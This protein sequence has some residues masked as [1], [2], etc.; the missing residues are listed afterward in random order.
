MSFAQGLIAG[1]RIAAGWLDAYESSD[2]KRR[3]KL[4]QEE[5]AK[6]GRTENM[7]EM[8]P[9]Y[10]A[11]P[12]EGLAPQPSM[13]RQPAPAPM[14]TGVS[15]ADGDYTSVPGMRTGLQASM[16]PPAQ[17]PVGAGFARGF[18][19]QQIDTARSAGMTM[20]VS[21]RTQ[22]EADIYAKYGLT[23]DAVRSRERAYDLGRQ[24]KSDA[25]AERL[26][27]RAEE[28]YGLRIGETKRTLREGEA[29]RNA[30]SALGVKLAAGETIDLPAIYQVATDMGA[31]PTVLTAFVGD[32]L[33]INKKI[34]DEKVAKMERE[35]REA[36]SS[37]DKLNAY[38]AKNVADPNPDDNIL[39][40]LRP[41]KGGWGIFYGKDL[42]KGTQIYADTKEIPGFQ[43]LAQDMIEKAK[44]NPLGWTIQ[45]LTIEKEAAA[46]AASKASSAASAST[47]GLNAIRGKQ[48]EAQTK[49]LNANFEGN[50]EARKIQKQLA[51][52]DFENDPLAPQKQAN[53]LNQINTL[54]VAPGKTVP[55]G[56][57]K[58]GGLLKQAVDTKKNDDGTYTAYKK[59][60]GEAIYN[61][62]NGEKIPL[63]ME[64]DEYKAMKDAAKK[65]GVELYR[66]ED[67]G[68]LGLAFVGPDGQPYKDPEK[69]KYSKPVPVEK[70][71]PAGEKVGL[72]TTPKA[73]APTPP[74]EKPVREANESFSAFRD[75][76]VAWDKNRMA[77]EQLLSDQRVREMLS[78]NASG[79]QL[80][81]RPMVR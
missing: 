8:A 70:A 19:P 71:S 3:E 32:S 4:A 26:D 27:A 16:A 17:A 28:E 35:V 37:P 10:A 33:G 30:I 44:G 65:N 56:G 6:I 1:D 77:Y 29:N 5:I 79:L 72:A 23:K 43:A 7:P 57:A 2:T 66:V 9:N 47:S 69:A 73:T 54:N 40:E 76:T 39:P 63:G 59:D 80:N 18:T 81:N 11:L 12:A 68:A 53:L 67:N 46:I 78:G 22:Q 60:T 41:V 62:Y 25:R 34:A 15:G 74:T 51:E 36:I 31:N 13:M 20:P 49:I 64:I 61:T 42:L 38:I 24:E 14:G 21:Q 75:R 45:K 52:L 48:I 50:E 58:G 55:V